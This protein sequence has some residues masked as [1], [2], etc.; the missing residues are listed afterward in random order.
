M[1]TVI[2]MGFSTPQS[3][4]DLVAETY[5]EKDDAS[6]IRASFSF[7]LAMHNLARFAEA[8][9]NNEYIGHSAAA[10][11]LAKAMAEH[12]VKPAQVDLIAPPI[13]EF[14]L[15]HR[16]TVLGL[17]GRGALTFLGDPAQHEEIYN[18]VWETKNRAEFFRDPRFHIKMIGELAVFDSIGLAED[19]AGKHEIS[20]EMIFMNR[21]GLFLPGSAGRDSVVRA[22]EAGVVMRVI[23]G[24]HTC[25]TMDPAGVFNQIQIDRD[26]GGQI[27]DYD[28]FVSRFRRD[29]HK[30][31]G[32]TSRR[33]AT[34]ARN[35]IGMPNSQPSAA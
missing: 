30:S 1:E 8:V 14:A 32:S 23:E 25:L 28:D 9:G 12:G 34:T 29:D 13:R 7:Y 24:T 19:L 10:F 15:G 3:T 16:K 17:L 5:K 22:L 27:K 2:G 4:A 35:L 26:K 6:A 20:T 11:A 33:I 18:K 21:D 31:L